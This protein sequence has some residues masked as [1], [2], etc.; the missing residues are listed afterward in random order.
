VPAGRQ[1][2][3]PFKL[4]VL[5]ALTLAAASTG[6]VVPALRALVDQAGL[7]PAA[8]GL[9]M[10]VH[11]I[12]GIAGAAWGK[13]ALRLAGS[14]RMLAIAA[15]I[16]S[17]AVTLA[18]A[19]IDSFAIRI[20]LRIV[21]GAC[22]LLAITALVAAGTAGDPE[23]RVRRAVALGIAIVLGV[24]GGLG[25]GAALG[26]PDLALIVAALL[27]AG[28]LGT[29]IA[30]VAG[31]PVA[32][33]PMA[34]AP[35]GLAAGRGLDR[36]RFAAGLLAFGERF[37]F[38]ILTVTASYLASQARVGLVL[39]VFMIASVI[40]MPLARR[41][42]AAVGPRKLAVRGT[43]GLTLALVVAAFVDVFG[44]PGVAVVWAIGCGAAAGAL[45]ATALVLVARS[46]ALEDRARDMATVQAAGSA[47]HALGTLGAGVF[48][49]ALPGTLAFAVPGIAMILAA[50]LGVWLTVPDAARDCP[51]IGGLAGLGAVA[52]PKLGA[53]LGS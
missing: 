15:L 5:A 51:V 13:R 42:A 24:V 49:A 53:K 2:K 46:A 12:G 3:L 31:E 35:A 40:A 26:A 36:R 18:I 33:E 43:L 48:A 9:F 21:D 28:A 39:G 47:G 23:L 22:H 16:A 14:A 17:V 27:S 38:G 10:S 37:L 30:F 34:A 50:T 7:G 4:G 1:S 52:P 45:Y 29:A 41:H 11:V 19:A 32:P 6:V 20:G 44:S 8:A 25:I